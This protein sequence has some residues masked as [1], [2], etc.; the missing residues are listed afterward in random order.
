MKRALV[1]E[2]YVCVSARPKRDGPD[3]GP[4]LH[5]RSEIQNRGTNTPSREA[6][7]RSPSSTDHTRSEDLCAREEGPL[8]HQKLADSRPTASGERNQ[9]GLNIIG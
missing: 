4:A 6:N 1:D 8:A 7:G 9:P 5:K 3:L 2:G